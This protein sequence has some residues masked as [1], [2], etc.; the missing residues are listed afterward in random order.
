MILDPRMTVAGVVA[1]KDGNM[2]FVVADLI[3]P[4][5][6]LSIEEVEKRILSSIHDLRRAKDM[7]PL[8]GLWSKRLRAVAAEMAKKDSLNVEISDPTDA[9][10]IGSAGPY[11][12]AVAYTSSTPWELPQSIVAM[13]KDPK[14]NTA[15]VGVYF[16]K[17]K[18]YPNGIYWIVVQFYAGASS[19]GTKRD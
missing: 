6:G 19:S 17:S 3:Q 12:R 8:K 15:A 10:I 2:W 16:A 13:P 11:A 18:T 7:T 4:Q 5:Q 9:G 14:I 1:A